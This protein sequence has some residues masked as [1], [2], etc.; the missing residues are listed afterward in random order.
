MDYKTILVRCDASKATSPRLGVAVELAER[1]GAHLIG[2]YARW[3]IEP[4]L[5]F[6]IGGGKEIDEVIRSYAQ[7]VAADKAAA[8]S[9]FGEATKGK[10]ITTEWR[11]AEGRVIADVSSLARN[12]DLIVA[13]Q[14]EPGQGISPSNLPEAVALET[15]RPVLVVPYVGIQKAPGRV[16]MLCWNASREAAR[17]ASDALPLLKL[18][19]RVIVLVVES[20]ASVREHGAQHDTDVTMWLKRHGVRVTL[21]KDVAPDADVGSAILSR[22]ADHGVDMIVMG[23]YGHSR[24]WEFVVGGVSRTLLAEMTVPLFIAH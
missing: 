21:K 2:L 23:L 24:I 13:G 1:F 6:D 18:A 4:P 14:A 12:V 7:L 10:R 20:T 9:A 22:A 5:Y 11:V 19:E 3:P 8:L 15:G 16:V 17:A